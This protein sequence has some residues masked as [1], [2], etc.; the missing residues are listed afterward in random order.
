MIS[1][2]AVYL[3]VVA[4]LTYVERKKSSTMD[5]GHPTLSFFAGVFIHDFLLD[6]DEDRTEGR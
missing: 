4:V 6:L 1:N 3:I 2:V 5:Q